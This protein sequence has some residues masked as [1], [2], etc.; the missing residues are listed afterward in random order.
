MRKRPPEETGQDI[1]DLVDAVRR[2][3]RS[4]GVLDTPAGVQALRVA[5]RMV[6]ATADTGSSY[7]ALS[8]E[9]SRALDEAKSA[10]AAAKAN[11]V[12]EFTQ[13]RQQRRGA[14]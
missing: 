7:A 9:L 6:S 8:R 10:P 4:A 14:A 1:P 2:D 12:D 3:L 5:N 13:R 11:P